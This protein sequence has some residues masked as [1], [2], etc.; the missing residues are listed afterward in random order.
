[1]YTNRKEYYV[2]QNDKGK[3]FKLDNISGGYPI[4]IDD[5]EF[6][7]KFNSKQFAED[8]LKGDYATK[9]FKKE[10]ENC[11]VRTVKMILE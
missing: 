7:E 5:F 9:L 8:F 4:F 6:C 3:F 10:F 2:I 11:V 1:M